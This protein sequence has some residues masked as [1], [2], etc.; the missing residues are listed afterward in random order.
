M[1]FAGMLNWLLQ[2][3]RIGMNGC[4]LTGLVAIY[5]DLNSDL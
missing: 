5:Y 3:S 4:K 2:T 1:S